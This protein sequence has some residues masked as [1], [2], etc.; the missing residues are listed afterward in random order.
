M[1]R[2]SVGIRIGLTNLTF[3]VLF[4]QTAFAVKPTVKTVPWAAANPL[5]AHDTFSGKQITLKGAADVQGT[6]FQWIWDFGDGTPVASGTVTNKYVIE[7]TH[8]YAGSPGQIFTAQLSV[9]DMNTGEKG[10]RWVSA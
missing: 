9:Q 2:G 8:A 1:R 3:C 6:N 5:I 7:A 10:S 4:S